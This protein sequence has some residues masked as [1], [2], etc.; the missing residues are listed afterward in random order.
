[1]KILYAIQGTGNGHLSRAKEVIPILK[2]KCEVDILISGIQVDVK[3]AHAVKYNI[4]GLSY[5]FG[6]NGGID[7]RKTYLKSK[8]KRFYNEIKHLPVEKYDLIISDFEPVA[9]WAAKSKSVPCIGLSHQCAV[10]NEFAPKPKKTNLLGK[11]ILKKYAPVN[12]AYGFHF[13]SYDTNIFTPIIRQEI[14]ALNTANY[15][16]YTVYLPSYNDRK[17]LKVLTHITEI[18]WQVFS[19]H[20]Q[21]PFSY[22]NVEIMPVDTEK[23]LESFSNC[24][25]VLCGAGFEAS[26]ESLFLGKKLMVI[27]MKGQ[28][29]QQCNAAALA[30]MGVPMIKKLKRKNIGKIKEWIA[31]DRIIK[32]NYPDETEKIIDYILTKH[33]NETTTGDSKIQQ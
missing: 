33:T 29:E 10:L 4:K 26:A 2:K 17:I 30:D 20:N 11:L 16:H 13:Q 12:K 1:M 19:K 7:Y 3:L 14:R 31:D 27:P 18:K 25:G 22:K 9:A 23:F 6:K 28:Y 15:G 8:S 32:V 5:I 21:K 24:R